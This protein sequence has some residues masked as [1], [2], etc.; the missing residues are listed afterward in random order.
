MIYKN[1]VPEIR[2]NASIRAVKRLFQ[3][4]PS[5]KAPTNQS[6]AFNYVSVRIVGM[7]K[8]NINSVMLS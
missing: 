7:E 3:H 1:D 5:F 4:F 6:K 2:V 8:I